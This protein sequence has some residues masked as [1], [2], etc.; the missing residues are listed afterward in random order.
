MGRSVL[1]YG[2]GVIG[3]ELAHVLKTGGNDVTLLAR[4]EWKSTLEKQ[5][6]VIRHYLQRKTTTDAIPV[7]DRLA[8]DDKYDVIFVVMQADQLFEVLPVVAAN[9]SRYVVLVGNNPWAEETEQRI[10]SASPME[11][12]VAFGFM[13][14]GGRRENGQ[15]ISIHAGVHITAGGREKDLS[16]E[17]RSLLSEVF[18]GSG[19]K[20]SWE[21]EMDAWL[22]CHMAEILPMAYVAYATG[23]D[24]TNASAAQR[25][26]M[27][28]A[29]LEGLTL[30]KTLGYPIRP[31]G[32]EDFFAGGPKRKAWGAVMVVACKTPLGRLA[33]TDHCEHAVSEMTFLD[34]AWEQLR[35]QK[36]ELPMPVWD[37]LRKSMPTPIENSRDI[38]AKTNSVFRYQTD[39]FHGELFRPAGD[40]YPGKVLICF[41]GSDGKFELAKGLAKVFAKQGLTAL[42]LAYVMEEGLPNCFY[43]IPIDMLEAAAKRLHE[44]GYE[45]VG[46]WGISKGAELALTAGSLLPG[47][48]N[49]VVAVAPMSTVCQG[50]T[51]KKGIKI[52]PGSSWSF[53]GEEMP[54]TGFGLEKFP[55]GRV[56]RKSLAAR[57]LTMYDN[58]RPMI[59]KPNPDAVIRV[60]NITGPVLLITSQMDTM[61]PSVPAAEKI[62]ERLRQKDFAYPYKHL[63]YKYGSHLFVPMETSLA[64]FFAGDRGKYRELGRKARM[65]S[66]EKTLEFLGEW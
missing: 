16:A 10:L 25:K 61:W 50:F 45:K 53:H 60:E 54:Y 20:L 9:A 38:P 51:K 2:A 37:S 65:D 46:L 36:P 11:K 28:D 19:C 1:I 6:L 27:I 3:C 24:L 29:G 7:T 31:A 48:V 57:E 30:L 35:R 12:E 21:H 58:Y 39:G 64:K 59:Q 66:L 18:S 26:A 13:G 44:M 23:C 55:L 63:N 41:S 17:F 62:M 52:L 5:G 15:V 47:L 56:L 14:V 34:S 43:H 49:A 22:K 40:K 33:V 42:A 8:P 4:G 32:D